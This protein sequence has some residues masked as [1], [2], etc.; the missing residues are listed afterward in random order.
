MPA[1]SRTRSNSPPED[2]GRV[3]LPWW[4]IALP[5]AAFALLLTLLLGPV[6][7]QAASGG[8]S[9]GGGIPPLLGRLPEVLLRLLI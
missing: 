1:G 6:E 2:G 4:A 7:A 8:V 3:W 5:A 9:L